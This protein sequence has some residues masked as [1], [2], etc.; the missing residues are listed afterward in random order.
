MKIIYAQLELQFGLFR[1]VSPKYEEYQYVTKSS[2]I[3]IDGS[4]IA[5]AIRNSRWSG[6]KWSHVNVDAA[7]RYAGIVRADVVRKL[8]EWNESGQIEMKVS[9]VRHV[10]RLS[11]KL[12]STPEE[13][14][15]IVKPLYAYLLAR[16][17]EDLQRTKEVVS[18]ITGKG[19]ITYRLA[20]HF[21]DN[22]QGLSAECGHC[23]WCETHTQVSLPE[24]PPVSPDPKRIDDVLQACNERDDPRFLARIAFGIP[25]PRATKLKLTKHPAWE[26][27]DVC[28]FMVCHL[29]T[30]S[31]QFFCLRS[32]LI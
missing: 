21:G 9:G 28:D 23:V 29:F 27:M 18:L 5:T 13:M 16:E 2:S 11:R 25:S 17:Q 26:S 1:A 20:A 8:N 22:S 10:Y 24:M 6:P 7:A 32:M 14:E 15:E 30:T 4:P 19:C 31:F 3:E 12:P